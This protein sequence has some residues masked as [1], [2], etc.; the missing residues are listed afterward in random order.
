MSPGPREPLC[1]SALERKTTTHTASAQVDR[2]GVRARHALVAFLEVPQ[3]SARRCGCEKECHLEDM[4]SNDRL[5]M[6]GAQAAPWTCC[7]A[8]ILTN[9]STRA[10]RFETRFG[11][12]HQQVQMDDPNSR[13]TARSPFPGKQKGIPHP[14]S[15]FGAKGAPA[16]PAPFPVSERGSRSPGSPVTARCSGCAR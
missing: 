16:V 5:C 8:Y 10:R 13:A 7:G 2:D 9:V 3:L 12:K 11:V 4:I 14:Q 15:L 6:R 1:T